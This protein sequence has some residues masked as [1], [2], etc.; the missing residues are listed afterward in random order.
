MPNLEEM[1]KRVKLDGLGPEQLLELLVIV[2]RCKEAL[3]NGGSL[4]LMPASAVQDLAK[5]VPDDLVQAIV[6]DHRHGPG[7][8]GW[9]R[10]DAPTET[11]K[12]RGWQNGRPLAGSVPGIRHVDRI[13]EG[14]AAR[15]K[16]EQIADMVETARK[17]KG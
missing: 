9:L 16:V 6:H 11:V 8:P 10:P 1:L 3:T 17:L 5:A 12:S 15:D 4:G 7:E 13:A 2:R 14:F